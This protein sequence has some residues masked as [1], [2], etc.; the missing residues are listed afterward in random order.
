MKDSKL[1]GIIALAV[2][3]IIAFAVIY[4]SKILVKDE[5][6]NNTDNGQVQEDLP[7]AIEVAGAEGIVSAREIT[8][9][10]GSVTAYSVVSEAKGFAPKPV[11][12]EIVFESNA[13]TISEVK[14]VSHSET[15]GYGAKMEEDNYLDQFKG[16]FAPIYLTGKAPV[17]DTVADTPDV[18][19]GLQDGIYRVE[20]DE[21]DEKG[22]LYM[23]TIKVENGNITSLVFD[24]MNRE[25][26]Y[27]S[28]LSTVGEYTMTEDGPTWKEQA[29]SLA[30]YVLENQ[31]IEGLTVDENGKTDTVS[32]VSISIGNFLELV[33]SALVKAA[34]GEGAEN[35]GAGD[36]GE[37]VADGGDV[38]EI[39]AISGAT[40]TTDAILK[41]VNN[42]YE[43]ISA[44]TSK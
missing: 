33:E 22:Y 18:A 26:E 40:V 37:V 14:V 36:A 16:I 44:Y 31:S 17:S 39:D 9:A 27:K 42:A 15:P 19:G 32:G 13:K 28:Y 5:T 35:T 11:T 23:L 7:G 1:K 2:V 43:F 6:D 29:D 38:G 12:L 4:G 30:N 10:S 3:T 21:A 24:S 8:D 25:G 20:A 34:S 41:L